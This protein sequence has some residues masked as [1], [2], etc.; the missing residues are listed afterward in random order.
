M[1]QIQSING[2]EQLPIFQSI[3]GHTPD[4]EDMKVVGTDINNLVKKRSHFS[5]LNNLT[6]IFQD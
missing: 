1:S 4:I 5:A 2:A 3:Q 6:K